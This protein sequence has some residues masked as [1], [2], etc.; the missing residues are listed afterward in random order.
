[1]E[2]SPSNELLPQSC[3]YHYFLVLLLDSF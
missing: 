2:P 3:Y 1:M